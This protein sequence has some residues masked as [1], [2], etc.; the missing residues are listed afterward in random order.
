M[1]TTGAVLRHHSGRRIRA[2]RDELGISWKETRRLRGDYTADRK[3][4]DTHRGRYD[5]GFGDLAE[6]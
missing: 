6:G 5:V 4:S 2:S 3:K 1:N